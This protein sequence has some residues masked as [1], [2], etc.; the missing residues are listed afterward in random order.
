MPLCWMLSAC[1]SRETLCA[2]VALVALTVLYDELGAHAG[3]WLTRNTVNAMGFASFEVG[4]SLIAGTWYS[5]SIFI[6][7]I[8]KTNPFR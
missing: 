1:Y 5:M 2:S 8:C 3:H 6:Q 4:A 7:E